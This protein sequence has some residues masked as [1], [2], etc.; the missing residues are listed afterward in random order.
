MRNL[1]NVIYARSKTGYELELTAVTWAGSKSLICAFGPS[2]ENVLLQ[3]RHWHKQ[4]PGSQGQASD[5]PNCFGDISASWD[6]PCPLPDL[7]C[8]Q[9]INLHYFPDVA[10]ACLVLAGGD[11]V[12]VRESH[13]PTDEKIEIVGSVDVGISAASWSPD[14]E[15]LVISTRADTLLYMTRDF[16]N[17]VQVQLSPDDL[18]LSKHVSVGWGK[19]ETQFKGKGAKVL[20]DPTMPETVDEGTLSEYDTGNTSISWR[21]DGAFVAVNSIEAHTRRVVRVYSRDGSLDSVSEP[22]NGLTGALSWRPAG[23]LIASIQRVPEGVDVVFFERNG[24]RH[25]Q[26]TLRLTKAEMDDWATDISIAWN[27]DST[28]LA[29]CFLDRVQLWTMGNY[30]Y[31]LKQEIFPPYK[32]RQTNPL[33]VQWSSEKPLNLTLYNT[34]KT[35][36]ILLIMSVTIAKSLVG[37]IQTL[38][39]ESVSCIGPTATPNDFGVVAVID[40]SILKVTPMRLAN[41]PPPMALHELKLHGNAIDVAITARKGVTIIV[42]LFHDALSCYEWRLPEDVGKEPTHKWITKTS[43]M[44]DAPNGHIVELEK[45]VNQS[46][47]FDR[48]GRLSTIQ[49]T[50]SGSVIVAMESDKGKIQ[51]TTR[52]SEEYQIRTDDQTRLFASIKHTESPT[53][54]LSSSGRLTVDGRDICKNC[55]S[56]LKTP[57]HLI[58][59]TSQHLLKFV[60]ITGAEKMDV[61][62]D[63]PESDERCR[64][65]ERGAKLVTVM[66]SIC[67]L[68]LQMPRGNLE[69]IYPRALVL[70]GIRDSIQEKKYRKAFLACRNHRVDMNIMH[71]YHPQA[72]IADVELF[73]D[74]VRKVEHIDLFL[75][76]LRYFGCSLSCC[77]LPADMLSGMKMSPK[78]CTKTHCRSQQ[79]RARILL[80]EHCRLLERTIHPKSI[81]YA[82]P[83]STSFDIVLQLICKTSLQLTF[84]RCHQTLTQHCP[85]LLDCVWRAPRKPK[86]LQSTSAFWPTRTDCMIMHLDFMTLKLHCW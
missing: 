8:D 86:V 35:A 27:V 32:D 6:A 23:N 18:K 49:S 56:F 79:H 36:T 37:G 45:H 61:P 71:D 4:K 76:Q 50:I 78:Q 1:R 14:E 65:I 19:S 29:V 54:V 83:S 24:L 28:V 70:A 20:R 74:E 7:E 42:V 12:V 17:V 30:H 60:H 22:V 68:V 16:E 47:F 55:T 31:Y 11:I 9:V 41:I 75:S 44:M 64:S 5:D 77:S 34:S 48:D 81:K 2:K 33:G 66:P 82:M 59:T 62:A 25:G 63:T 43:S 84:A 39:Y 58:F 15:L 80:R 40:G 3:V 38:E 46:V 53:V 21:G 85:R 13:D 26:F 73:V 69:T 51:C 57:S 67:A 72:F 10:T 52:L